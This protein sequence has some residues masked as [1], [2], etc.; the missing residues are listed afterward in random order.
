[1][2]LISG[3]VGKEKVHYEAPAAPLLEKEMSAFFGCVK[4][5]EDRTDMVLRVALAHLW[6]VTIHPFDDGNGRIAR[7][8]ADWAL[9]RSEDSPQ[10]FYI[11]LVG[12]TGFEPATPCAQ[13]PRYALSCISARRQ[14][15]QVV[16]PTSVLPSDNLRN[17]GVTLPGKTGGRLAR[18]EGR[19]RTMRDHRRTGGKPLHSPPRRTNLRGSA[20]VAYCR[21]R[22]SAL[23]I[24]SSTASSSL[25]TSSA[26]KRNTK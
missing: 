11:L 18:S 15:L 12:A 25:P 14:R 16:D 3:P 19:P 13:E 23:R 1:M 2:R 5:T 4:D 17:L 9:A 22:A 24:A 21:R 6:F 20:L 7:A 26:R 8:V 10:R